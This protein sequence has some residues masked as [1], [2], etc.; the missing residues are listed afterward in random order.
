MKALLQKALKKRE[1]V[2]GD[3]PHTERS[4][5]DKATYGASRGLDESDESSCTEEA[6]RVVQRAEAKQLRTPHHP[7][8]KRIRPA[9]DGGD[10]EATA[11]EDDHEEGSGSRRLQQKPPKKSPSSKLLEP[12]RA[13]EVGSNLT[14]ICLTHVICCFHAIHP[15]PK[16]TGQALRKH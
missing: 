15:G 2:R 10:Q 13:Y 14:F 11:E 6:A 5:P 3:G 9:H 16:A 8:G 12:T 4:T 7:E 1:S